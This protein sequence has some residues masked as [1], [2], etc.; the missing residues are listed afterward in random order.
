MGCS[1]S[2]K[3]NAIR[4]PGYEDPELLA[5]ALYELFKKLSSSIIDDCLI[6]KISDVKQNGVI[7][8][9]E[10]VRSLGVFHLSAPVHDKIKCQFAFKLYHLRQTG[11]IKREEIFRE[12]SLPVTRAEVKTKGNKALNTFYVRCFCD[13]SDTTSSKRRKHRFKTEFSRISNVFL[14]GVFK[15]RSFVNFGLIRS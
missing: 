4:P 6:L 1:V 11:F 2:K 14:F 13:W 10:F 5:A 12:N 8:F 3:K 9:G 7:E 15:S